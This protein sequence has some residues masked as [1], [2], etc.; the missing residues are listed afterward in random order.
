MTAKDVESKSPRR[1]ESTYI[2]NL[3]IKQY[4]TDNLYP[5]NFIR[6][7]GNSPTGTKC[8]DRF[9]DFIEGNGF[10]N[11]EFSE[12][13][14]NHKGQAVD[15]VLNLLS[16]DLAMFN[17]IAIHV[18]YNVNAQ[19]TEMQYVP[20]ENCRLCEPDSLGYVPK[21]AV[22][23]DWSGALTR[24]GER[25]K[26]DKEHVTYYDVFNPNSDVVSAQIERDGGIQN[27]KGQILW[28]T[29]DYRDEY[30]VGRGDAVITDMS[31][32]EALSN[33][34]WR[35]VRCNF[36]PAT[37][38]FTKQSTNVAESS[39]EERNAIERKADEFSEAILNFQ[40]DT[41]VGKIL[42]V[43]LENDESKPEFEQFRA[44][45]YDREFE[46]SEKSV[47][48]RIY[49]AFGQ[50]AW[51]SAR[52]GKVGFTGEILSSAFACYNS[53][54]RKYQRFLQRVF[55]RVSSYW[56][57]DMNPSGDYSIES[58]KYIMN[59]NPADFMN[60]AVSQDDV[61]HNS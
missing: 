40:G 13:I 21:I 33:V 55:K 36:L 60:P 50:E 37:M 41:N 2:R 35:N 25:I 26:V 59:Y 39:D 52:L 46:V 14:V 57:E 6:I 22:H 12:Y 31:T 42:E 7:V 8:I 47:T 17:G 61:N 49:A 27:Y 30:P 11:E 5:Q 3:G 43:T 4:G 23:P 10:N 19:I 29:I 32:D 34:K 44:Q 24:A 53:E 9:A 1:I 45:N 16:R 15:D 51:F 56:F 48:E 54:M 38:M 20:F 58:M 28:C 18:N